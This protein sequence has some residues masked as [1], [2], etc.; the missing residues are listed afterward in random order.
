MVPF[1]NHLTGSLMYVHESRVDEYLSAGHRPAEDP[2][3]PR[4]ASSSEEAAPRAETKPV[5]K[6]DTAKKSTRKKASK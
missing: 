2:S 1:I 4:E 6:S 3:T 5:S